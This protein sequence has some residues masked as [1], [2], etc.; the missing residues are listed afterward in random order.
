VIH[1]S[2][3]RCGQKFNVKPDFAGRATTCP[4][5]K[6]ALVVPQADVTAAY[7][8]SDKTR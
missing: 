6:Q 5:C 1:F 3:S 7:V 2:Y 8:P 4:A